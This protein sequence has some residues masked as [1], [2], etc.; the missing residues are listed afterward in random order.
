MFKQVFND[1]LI[2]LNRFARGA[3]TSQKVC[4]FHLG[5]CGSSVLADQLTQHVDICWG[6]EIFEKFIYEEFTGDVREI[7]KEQVVVTPFKTYGFEF[8]YLPSLHSSAIGLSLEEFIEVTKELGFDKYIILSRSN[9]LRRLV[10]MLVGVQNRRWHA[11]KDQTVLVEKIEVDVDSICEGEVFKSLHEWFLEYEMSAEIVRRT[12][13]NEAVLEL[14]YEED[15]LADP[16]L[17]YHKVCEFLNLKP[18]Q[19][20]VRYAQTNPFP[21]DEIVV[22]FSEI[23]SALVGT[24]YEWMLAG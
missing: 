14:T 11:A 6:G 10:S 8:K 7:L 13:D 5:R 22:N 1:L 17:A 24:K 16:K 12:I 4:L 23:Q 15:I 21:L 9:Y 3:I 2:D 19:T 20:E 18:T